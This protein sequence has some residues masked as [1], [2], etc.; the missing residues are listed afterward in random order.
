MINLT[1]EAF[2]HVEDSLWPNCCRKVDELARKYWLDDSTIDEIV[3]ALRTVAMNHCDSDTDTAS[4]G[5]EDGDTET[6]YTNMECD[7]DSACSFSDLGQMP[8]T[9]FNSIKF[10]DASNLAPEYHLLALSWVSYSDI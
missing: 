7:T 4:S 3:D 10:Q 9:S 1:V 2:D 5:L 8:S 6:A